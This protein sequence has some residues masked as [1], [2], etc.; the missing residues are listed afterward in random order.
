LFDETSD[1][2]PP[3]PLGSRP[4][5]Q[6]WLHVLLEETDTKQ[7]IITLGSYGYDWTIGGK[8]AELIS[9]PEAM[10]RAYNAELGSAEVSGPGYNPYFYFQEEDKEHAVW[11]FDVAT[12]LNELREVRGAKAGGFGLYR[13]GTE[14]PAIRDALAVPRD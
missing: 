9:F 1:I 4:W 3:G 13:L 8:K 12:F 11:F 5:F 7:W 6:G 10:S 14:D 2:D